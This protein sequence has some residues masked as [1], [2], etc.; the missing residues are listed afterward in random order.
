MLPTDCEHAI[1]QLKPLSLQRHQRDVIFNS[2]SSKNN[3][4]KRYEQSELF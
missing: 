3:K 1:H 2:C 4:H